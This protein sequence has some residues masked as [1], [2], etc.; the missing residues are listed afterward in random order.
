MKWTAPLAAVIA[1]LFLTGVAGAAVVE[2]PKPATA[3]RFAHTAKKIDPWEGVVESVSHFVETSRGL[4]FKR[5]VKS[6]FLSPAAFAKRR[7]AGRQVDADSL[8]VD[9]ALGFVDPAVTAESLHDGA[10][11]DVVGFYDSR[12]NEL[13]V[14]GEEPTPYVRFVLAHELTHALQDQHFNLNRMDRLGGIDETDIG[15]WTLAE[16]DA[17]RVG[18][19]YFA[20]LSPDDQKSIEAIEN[21]ASTGATTTTTI[22]KGTPPPWPGNRANY[23]SDLFPYAVGPRL[24]QRLIAEGGQKLLD[25]TFRRPIV[26]SE[27]LLLADKAT[28]HEAPVPVATPPA[29]GP[30]ISEGPV[31]L[32]ALNQLFYAQWTDLQWRYTEWGGGRFVAWKQGDAACVRFTVVM[33]TADGAAYL[34]TAL[35]SVAELHGNSNVT[36]PKYPEI[37][38]PNFKLANAPVTY[39]TC[40]PPVTRTWDQVQA[41]FAAKQNR[42]MT[43]FYRDNNI[44]GPVPK[45]QPQ[46]YYPPSKP[47]WLNQAS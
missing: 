38:Q 2:K 9:K 42:Q 21:P 35:E 7:A 11:S 1:A 15:L 36:G 40:G 23:Y 34:R 22:P 41:V 44:T 39:T 33:D 8:L 5:P 19:A 47:Y 46:P 37:P 45:Y 20:S 31:G 32:F 27:Q 6:S 12:A 29:D 25:E 17:M 28:H 18:D 43:K 13:F 14:L 16:G 3:P 4:T 30:V 24:V 26:S 10:D